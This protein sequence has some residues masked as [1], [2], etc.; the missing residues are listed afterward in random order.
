MQPLDVQEFA[1]QIEEDTK[2]QSNPKNYEPRI[3]YDPAAVVRTPLRSPS[4]R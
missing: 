2:K 1:K 3:S 4:P